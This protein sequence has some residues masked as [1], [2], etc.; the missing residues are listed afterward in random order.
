MSLSTFSSLH[1]HLLTVLLM[2]G[3][4]QHMSAINPA[5]AIGPVEQPWF[6]SAGLG[7]SLGQCTFR[8]ITESDSHWGFQGGLT[9][10]YRYNR[11][12]TYE[13]GI[14][15][16]TQ[17]ETALDCCPYWLS[18][19]GK[20]YSSPVIDHEGWYYRDLK[21]RTG[22]AKVSVQANFNTLSLFLEP[23]CR[24]DLN[25][26]PQLSVVTTK[27]KLITPSSDITND[28]QWHLGLG[29][30]FSTSYRIND[31]VSVLF[32]CGITCL[33]GKRFDDIPE[34]I[35]TPNLIWDAGIKATYR[36]DFKK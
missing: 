13:A 31:D 16:G 18:A 36:L 10:G 25:L 23:D 7:T 11:L 35:H 14:Q 27:S 12:I 24:W 2:A 8:S 20:R 5:D 3:L 15:L 4:S 6:V 1:R 30:Q 17:T 26:S 19:D 33:T 21:S 9:A 32:Y 22:W 28:R 34:H 29:G